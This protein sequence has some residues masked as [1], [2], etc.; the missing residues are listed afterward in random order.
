[1]KRGIPIFPLLICL[2]VSSAEKPLLAASPCP[3]P[4]LHEDELLFPLEQW[5]NH[6]SCIVECPNGD[7]LACWYNGSG[8]RSA[9]DVKVL[10]ARKQK[11]SQT[12]SKPFILA[13]TPGFPDTNPCLFIDPQQRLWLIWQTIIA[14]QWHTALAKYKIAWMRFSDFKV[15]KLS[16]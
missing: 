7:L 16:E 5:H 10:G 1:M 13:E 6:A 12:W 11:G 2:F 4:V 9:D 15:I 3:A 8:E 14:N